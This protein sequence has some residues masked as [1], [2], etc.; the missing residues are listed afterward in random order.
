MLGVAPSLLL[1]LDQ[2]ARTVTERGDTAASP[3]GG[4]VLALAHRPTAVRGKLPR[5]SERYGVYRPKP[6]HTTPS[7]ALPCEYPGSGSA[8]THRKIEPAA[9]SM[10]SGLTDAFDPE[11]RET[12][13][14]PHE[15]P[16]L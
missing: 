8:L 6:P 2:L 14:L 10:T 16:S 4:R 13:L 15:H 9:V 5:I 7:S 1:I 3:H 11:S 12:E